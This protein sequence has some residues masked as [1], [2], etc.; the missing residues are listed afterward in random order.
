MHELGITRTIVTI[1]S[2]QAEGGKV[3][4]V[5]LE[6]GQLSAVMP[7]AIRFCFDVVSQGTVLQGAQLQINETPGRA[8]CQDCGR[9]FTLQQLPARCVCDSALLDILA[10]EDL[11]VKEIEVI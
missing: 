9:E 8:R 2:E 7:D 10:G 11:I 3:I 5:L 6:I 4:R 1:A